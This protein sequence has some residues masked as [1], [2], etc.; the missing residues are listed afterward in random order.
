MPVALPAVTVKLKLP[1]AE[2]E[3]LIAAP[4]RVKP[5]GRLPVTPKLVGVLVAVMV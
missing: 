1:A 3:P 4:L 2:G 5:G